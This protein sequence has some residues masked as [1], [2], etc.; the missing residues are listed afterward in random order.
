MYRMSSRTN[1]NWLH[2]LSQ[3]G[4]SQKEALEELRDYLLRV[5]L[6]YLRDFGSNIIELPPAEIR[7][8]AEDMAQEALLSIRANLDSF[9]GES[10]FTTWAYRFAINQTAGEL[11]L[12]RYTTLSLDSVMEQ[13]ESLFGRFVRDLDAL[14][15]ELEAERHHLLELLHRIIR[16]DLTAR[17]REA[18]IAVHIRGFAMD[19]VAEHMNTNRNTLYKLL[20]DAR[21]KIKSRLLAHHLSEGDILALFEID[22]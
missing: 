12:Q 22:S 5:V 15:P 17:Q 6:I 11:R 14:D 16:E 1:E 21:Q 10:K 19:E 3:P 18:L 7:Q 8:F 4:E 9:R 20:H 13:R 2:A